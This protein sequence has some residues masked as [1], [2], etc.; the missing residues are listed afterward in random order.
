M[1]LEVITAIKDAESKAEEIKKQAAV[2][3]K[4]LLKLT[5]KQLKEYSDA[6]ISKARKEATKIISSFENEA[7][8]EKLKMRIQMDKAIE[9]IKKDTDSNMDS[10]INYILGRIV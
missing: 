1:A 7:E 3:G 8:Q 10:A 5:E 9:Q 2:K 6:E 4:E